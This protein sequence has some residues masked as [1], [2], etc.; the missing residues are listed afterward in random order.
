MNTIEINRLNNK[1]IPAKIREARIARA[2]S[3]SELSEKIGVSSQA[4]SQYEIGTSTPSAPILMNIIRELDFPSTFFYNPN[5]IDNSMSSSATYFRSNKNITKK[6]KE[7]FK[8]RIYWIDNV[9]NFLGEYLELPELNLPNFDDLLIDDELDS[10]KIEEIATRLRQYWNLGDGP[11]GNMVNLLQKNGFTIS[12][13]EFNNKKVDAFSRWYQGVPYI[14]LGSDKNSAVR[15]R[16]DLA[17]ELGH[18]IM[19]RHINQDDLSNKN[20]LDKIELEANQFAAAFLLPLSSFNKEVISSSINHFVILKERWKVSISAM[21]RRCS[22]ANILTDN[23]IRYLNSQMI[24]YNYYRKE[25]L[26]DVI[27]IEEPYLIKQGLNLLLENNILNKQ[28]V[29][30]ILS[31]NAIEAE[32][33]FCLGDNFFG[34]NNKIINLKVVN[35]R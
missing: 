31:L 27:K 7:A 9:R 32:K 8:V 20:T 22:D 26:D 19:H 14:V 12:R 17:H 15:S 10:L 33:L 34:E 1:I 23:Q 6:V 28:K 18:L 29:L 11:I 25:P 21:I 4:I 13:L 3:L 16:F 24:K 5:V 2:M 35:Q 30:D